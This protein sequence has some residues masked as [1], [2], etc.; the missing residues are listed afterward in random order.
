MK[1]QKIGGLKKS[2][3]NK[4][5]RTLQEIASGYREEMLGIL[6][7]IARDPKVDARTR[8]AAMRARA[9]SGMP[10]GRERASARAKALIRRI[11]PFHVWIRERARSEAE[12]EGYW[13]LLC[14]LAREVADPSPRSITVSPGRP[15][16]FGY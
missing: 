1:R 8:A 13:R 16:R 6:A 14:W 11:T 12:T 2:T 3:P 10:K 15:P 9:T 7:A 5:T 4:A